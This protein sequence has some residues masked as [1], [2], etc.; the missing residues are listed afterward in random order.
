[1]SSSTA[2]QDRIKRIFTENFSVGDIAEPLVSFDATA[3]T[4]R[5][6]D[7]IW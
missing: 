2:A 6:Q 3:T 5:G 4:K 1:M 7:P